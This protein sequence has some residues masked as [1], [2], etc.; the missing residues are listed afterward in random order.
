MIFATYLSGMFSI[1]MLIAVLT[2]LFA[3]QI[4]V[5]VPSL[6][7]IFVRNA[8]FFALG[9]IAF[10]SLLLLGLSYLQYRTWLGHPL[11]KFFLPPYQSWDYF[12]TYVG[13]KFFAPYAISLVLAIIF[14]AALGVANKKFGERFFE[15]EEIAL[16]AISIFLVGHPGWIFYMVLAIA[17]YLGLQIFY[18]IKYRGLPRVSMYYLW[19][20]L[21]LFVIIVMQWFVRL[22]A[23]KALKI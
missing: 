2:P 17:T 11:S 9:V 21:A 12:L 19:V 1:A 5:L 20:P 7:K 18:T 22:D 13:S 10:M 4:A 14:F 15:R 23:F 6:S 16:I 3:M 8:K